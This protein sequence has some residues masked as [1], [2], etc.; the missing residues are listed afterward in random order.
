MSVDENG[1]DTAEIDHCAPMWPCGK[2]P[3]YRRV[4]TVYA[5][6]DNHLMYPDGVDRRPIMIAS[7]VN[8]GLAAL[9]LRALGAR[10]VVPHAGSRRRR[11]EPTSTQLA[12][13]QPRSS[14]T[15]VNGMPAHVLLLHFIV[16]LVPLTALLEIVCGLWPAARRGLLLWLTL[17]L[18]SVTMVLTPITANAGVWLY[19]L[20]ANPSPILREHAARGGTMIYFS[21]ALLAVAVGLVVLRVT[22]R[23]FEKRRMVIHIVVGIMVLAIGIS[24]VIQVYR[25][26][27][28]G[29]RSV[30][31]EEI[32]RMQKPHGT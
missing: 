10:C 32:A 24:S 28:A 20:T 17:I 26:G 3:D 8:R 14:M 27:D 29:G 13:H 12:A 16:V 1:I 5:W 25:V 23:Q 21:A 9:S 4:Q 11:R 19:D 31:D 18:A 22:E 2:S 6:A 30:W 7:A 15:T